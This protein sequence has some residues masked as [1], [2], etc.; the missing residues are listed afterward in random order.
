MKK[1]HLYEKDLEQIL[2]KEDIF[3]VFQPIVSLKD[4][5]ISGYEALSRIRGLHSITD[6]KT[7]FDTA[8]STGHI[9]NLE[10][11]ARRKAFESVSSQSEGLFSGRFFLNVSPRIIYDQKFR[12]GFTKDLVRRYRLKPEQIVFEITERDSV[13]DLS[14]FLG[15]IEHYK[16]ESYQ[17]A[18]DDAGSGYSGLNLICDVHPHFIKLDMHLIHGIDKNGIQAAAIRGMVEL[19][20]LTN[21]RLIAEGIECVEELEVLINLGVHYGQGYYLGMPDPVMREVPEDIRE[22]IQDFNLKK[23]RSWMHGI[24]SYHIRNIAVKGIT[25]PPD[26][27]TGHALQYLEDHKEQPGICVSQGN[28]VVGILTREK[29]LSRL[30]GRYGYSLYQNKHISR[31]MDQNFLQ[32]DGY[33]PISAVASMAM[34]REQRDLYD[35]IVVTEQEQYSGI[36]TI[37]DLLRKATEIDVNMARSANPLTG[38][39]GNLEIEREM[40]SCISSQE[41]YT[42]LYFDLDNFKAFNDVYG[43]EKGDEI[44]RLLAEVIKSYMKKKDFLGHIG[45]DDFVAILRRYVSE[46]FLCRITSDFEE[47]AQEFYTPEDRSRGFIITSNRHGTTEIFPLMSVTIAGITSSEHSFTTSFELSKELS[48]RKKAEKKRKG[49]QCS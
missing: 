37:R 44:I 17:I 3:P 23:H 42:V 47:R 8:V 26:L 36:V 41:P 29:M 38:L 24:S 46:D 49:R 6:I 19:A 22:I 30:G 18:I 45:G 13:A 10:Q 35:F 12:S 7:L 11:L 48:F 33:T 32:V 25:V 9:W 14:G 27:V 1:N 4:G 20:N 2:K 31:I 16:K 21:I 34:E 43:F 28:K 40:D 15:V 39:P 5:S